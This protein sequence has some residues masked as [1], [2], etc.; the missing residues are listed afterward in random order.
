M[1][2]Q[3]ISDFGQSDHFDAMALFQFLAIR[4][5]RR[6]GQDTDDFKIFEWYARLHSQAL[7]KASRILEMR[8]LSLVTSIDVVHYGK[9]RAD[10]ILVD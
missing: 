4:E 7:D 2:A 3:L 5:L 10:H 6:R 8:T 9:R 1:Q